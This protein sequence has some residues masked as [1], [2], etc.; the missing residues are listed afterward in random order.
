VSDTAKLPPLPPAAQAALD[1][2]RTIE[3]IK[4]VREIERIGLKEAK[5]RV[6]A[7]R[8]EAR[9]SHP[10]FAGQPEGRGA[11]RLIVMLLLVLGLAW[12]VMTT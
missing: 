6:D 1:R 8:G 2:G 10:G 9:R 4:I 11:G 3:A 5:D 7:H 12:Y